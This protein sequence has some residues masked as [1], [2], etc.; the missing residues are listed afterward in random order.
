MGKF[1]ITRTLKEKY[2]FNLYSGK[3]EILLTSQ[4]Y[5]ARKGALK[6]LRCVQAIGLDAPIEDTTQK[7]YESCPI[8]K[9]QIKKTKANKYYFTLIANNGKAVATSNG[10]ATLKQ[11]KAAIKLVKNNSTSEH[12]SKTVKLTNKKTSK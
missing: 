1:I 11:A 2:Y 5:Q 12:Q 9:Y 6:G 3:E 10:Y 8:P 4:I 7:E